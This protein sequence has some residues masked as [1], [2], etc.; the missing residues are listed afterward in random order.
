M[1]FKNKKHR[2]REPAQVASL[3]WKS[4]PTIHVLLFAAYTGLVDIVSSC[5]FDSYRFHL[6]RFV[7][8]KIDLWHQQMLLL[9]LHLDSLM[10]FYSTYFKKV[11][12]QETIKSADGVLGYTE[13]LAY[14]LKEYV[15]PSGRRT[16]ESTHHCKES[17]SSPT[18]KQQSIFTINRRSCVLMLTLIQEVLL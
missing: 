11:W 6:K 10:N 7:R 13:K 4:L 2:T 14:F 17:Q 9:D 16:L 3:W 12:C 5:I 1:K 18:L 8:I 15:M